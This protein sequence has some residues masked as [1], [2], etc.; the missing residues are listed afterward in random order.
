LMIAEE[1][2]MT[3]VAIAKERGNETNKHT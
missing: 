3:S 1:G 2:R